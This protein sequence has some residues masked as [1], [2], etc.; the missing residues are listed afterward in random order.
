MWLFVLLVVFAVFV[1]FG[2][3]V[4]F[5]YVPEAIETKIKAESLA[6]KGSLA[7]RN[8]GAVRGI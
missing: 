1:G 7:D 3:S 2:I 8:K 4:Y 6:S 5:K